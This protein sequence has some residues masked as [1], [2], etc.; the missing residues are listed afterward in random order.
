MSGSSSRALELCR[1]STTEP[2]HK[3]KRAQLD[4]PEPVQKRLFKSTRLWS[5]YADLEESYG[6]FT[7]CKAV[8]DRILELKIATPQLVINYAAF[9]EEQNYFEESFKAY[10]KGVN[11]FSFPYSAEIWAIYLTKFVERYGGRK[12]ERARDLFEQV[13][14]K[15]PTAKK[16]DSEDKTPSA[17]VFYLMYAQLEENY[18]LAR[19]AMHVYDRATKA[20]PP[21]EK[22]DV[23]KIYI[24]RATDFFGIVHTRGIY[25]AAI[26]LLPDLQASEMCLRFS[27]VETKLGE[28]DRARDILA[29]GSQ[30]C[31]PRKDR[32]YWNK[33]H[34]FEVHHGNEDTFREM[35]RI[36]RSV[37]LQF[38]QISFSGHDMAAA[39]AAA[40]KVVSE[41][42]PTGMAAMEQRAEAQ[43]SDVGD[44]GESAGADN[45]DEIDIDMGDEDDEGDDQ[46]SGGDM[47]I[48]KQEVPAAVFGGLAEQAKSEQ[49]K[50]MGALERL[51]MK[52]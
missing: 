13:L 49:A 36:K 28:V 41:V 2:P 50:P 14:E 17:K 19:H 42:E 16:K 48:E 25:E 30:F 7:T 23:Y 24:N 43:A 20:L 40:H 35:L 21:A 5:L 1:R 18:G 51:K 37:Q 27:E 47:D 8:Y 11:L 12:L 34:Q 44:Q 46:T 38:T 15:V 31:D 9:L 45:P 29:H 4:G 39:A 22:Y 33:W 52:K 26:S 10:E 3:R 32:S 6:T